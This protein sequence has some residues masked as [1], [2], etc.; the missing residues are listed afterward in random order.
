V[1]RRVCTAS[2]VTVGLLGCGSPPVPLVPLAPAAPPR[3]VP[4]AAA[5]DTAAERTV[6][7]VAYE[8]KGRRDP[9]EP[10]EVTVG[11]K[12]L[13]VSSTRL[14]GI[15]RGQG[16]TLALLE[17]TDGI[18]YILREGDTL[19]DGRLVEIR[20][21]SAVFSVMARPGVASLVTLR[22]RTDL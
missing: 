19:G 10:I 7:P 13:T 8:P 22:L 9:F 3:P 1:I 14:T 4:V 6:E 17:G 16:E 21:D 18:G 12:G 2:L 20:A 11:V 5:P 15:I